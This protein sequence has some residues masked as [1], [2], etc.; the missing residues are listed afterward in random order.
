M[1]RSTS[2]NHFVKALSAS[3]S[4]S[5]KY[6]QWIESVFLSVNMLTLERGKGLTERD[7]ISKG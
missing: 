5:S 7:P 6:P 1:P 4:F 2:E 3:L